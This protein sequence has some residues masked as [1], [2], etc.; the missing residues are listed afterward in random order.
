[1]PVFFVCK[2]EERRREKNEIKMKGKVETT[3]KL[4]QNKRN[5]IS[6][7]GNNNYY[8]YYFGHCNN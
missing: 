6:C 1:M 4:K 3:K 2:F 7:V 8:P 5:Y